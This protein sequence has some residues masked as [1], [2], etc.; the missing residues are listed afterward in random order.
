LSPT[1]TSKIGRTLRLETVFSELVSVTIE[2]IKKV[3]GDLS[4]G[5]RIDNHGHFIRPT[6]LPHD[7]MHVDSFHKE[8]SFTFCTQ[9]M[10]KRSDSTLCEHVGDCFAVIHN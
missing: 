2:P 9:H 4:T 6:A 3:F 7:S 5:C 1:S 8:L 10:L